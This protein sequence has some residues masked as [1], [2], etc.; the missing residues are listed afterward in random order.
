MMLIT[1]MTFIRDSRVQTYREVFDGSNES[2]QH[3]NEALDPN[4]RKGIHTVFP[5]TENVTMNFG[6]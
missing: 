4:L 2:L 6:P 5:I 1:C 3:S